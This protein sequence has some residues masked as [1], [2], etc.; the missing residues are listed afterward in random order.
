M[1]PSRAGHN[2]RLPCR[3]V[4]VSSPNNSEPHA[5]LRVFALIMKPSP[6]CSASSRP[7]ITDRIASLLTLLVSG[8]FWLSSHAPA[9]PV[10]I[11]KY[12]Q[13][14]PGTSGQFSSFERPTVNGNGVVAFSTSLINTSLGSIN[15]S[16]IYLTG[17][18][19]IG[20]TKV[21]QENQTT[22]TLN[23]Q[24]A[25]FD[26]RHVPSVSEDGSIA[27]RARLSNTFGVADDWGIFRYRNDTLDEV[28][29]SVQYIEPGCYFG[30]FSV[31]GGNPEPFLDLQ[32]EVYFTPHAI[33]EA[34][35]SAPLLK[36]VIIF[37]SNG[38]EYD[39]LLGYGRTLPE[40]Y[41][42]YNLSTSPAVSYSDSG[43]AVAYATAVDTDTVSFDAAYVKSGPTGAS[44]VAHVGQ[45]APN[46]AG[47]PDGTIG[48]LLNDPP[49]VNTAGEVAFAAGITG[50]SNPTVDTAGIFLHHAG[51]LTKVV[52]RGEIAPSGNGLF[53]SFYGS[54]IVLNRSGDIVFP[55]TLTG[56][57]G[58]AL[59]SVGLFRWNRAD[60]SIDEIVRTG[61]VAVDG[62][63]LFVGFD[64]LAYNNKGQL[65]FFADMHNGNFSYKAI[66]FYDKSTGVIPVTWTGQSI[67]GG[68][69]SNLFFRSGSQGEGMQ[70]SGL[71]ARGHVAFSYW[72][73]G[74]GGVALW[75][76]PFPLNFTPPKPS[77]AING[78]NAELTIP[79]ESGLD[80]QLQRY[81]DDIDDWE[82]VGSPMAG[83][84]ENMTL[85]DD[86]AHSRTRGIYRCR[87]SE[88]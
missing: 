5:A 81:N 23:G 47:A 16:A 28:V 26:S 25:S 10:I 76:P 51:G 80:Y 6:L 43:I 55:A 46:S 88:D 72:S 20:L 48:Y 13:D 31:A 52:R 30:F 21:A 85:S 34:P 40:P 84:G 56:T 83:D 41:D 53:I 19:G 82:D 29:R 1:T 79:T 61:D 67:G 60:G 44:I 78:N 63:G 9:N 45:A 73:G 18:R 75:T 57:S 58:G 3:F 62:L 87:I 4:T 11:A 70:R 69:I 38:D 24:F 66:Y 15:N 74:Y 22:P 32:G 7:V 65:A 54:Q 14:A 49:M 86:T 68:T 37:R 35:N 36:D 33:A 17:A 71:S 64:D 39:D 50:S 8:S 42:Y 27:F 2:S 12:N 59:D 77:F